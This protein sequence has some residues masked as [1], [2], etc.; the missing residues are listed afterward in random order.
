MT[1]NKCNSKRML[2]VSAKCND[3]CDVSIGGTSKYGYVPNDLGIGGGDYVEFS[4]CLDCGTMSGDWP[5]PISKIEKKNAKKYVEWPV[6]NPDYVPFLDK[7]MTLVWANPDGGRD[8]ILPLLM[9]ANDPYMFIDAIVT[10]YRYGEE[11]PGIRTMAN[12]I[13]DLLTP[14]S[15]DEEW[16]YW[17]Q[18]EKVL[19]QIGAWDDKDDE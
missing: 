2:E 19:I 1:C 13:V 10:L 16:E 8:V 15:S 11:H 3:K 9:E 18:L 6:P 14:Y 4:V 7:M 12:S 17:P 5:M